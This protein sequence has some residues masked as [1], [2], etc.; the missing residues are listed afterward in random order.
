MSR[1]GKFYNTHGELIPEDSIVMSGKCIH[2][3]DLESTYKFK[4]EFIFN[5]S[6]AL[7]YSGCDMF[8]YFNYWSMTYE[9]YDLYEYGIEEF[10]IIYHDLDPVPVATVINVTGDSLEAMLRDIM[11]AVMRGD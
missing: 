11:R 10:V 5:I 4:D 8:G 3:D 7:D 2:P 9:V 1:I 6:T